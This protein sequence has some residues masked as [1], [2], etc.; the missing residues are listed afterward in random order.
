MAYQKIIFLVAGV[1]S[2][3]LELLYISTIWC[4]LGLVS[5][6]L[7]HGLHLWTDG[8]YGWWT[9]NSVHKVVHPYR[10]ISHFEMPCSGF[11]LGCEHALILLAPMSLLETR[12]LLCVR[13]STE[14]C[15]YPQ[16][17]IFLTVYRRKN[18]QNTHR[19]IMCGFAVRNNFFVSLTRREKLCSPRLKIIFL[20]RYPHRKNEICPD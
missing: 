15:E 13:K 10:V 14:K 1:D 16:K 17:N 18:T 19:N 20:C 3:M 5:K 12:I 4:G 8:L 9:S 6:R 11:F 7:T 2:R